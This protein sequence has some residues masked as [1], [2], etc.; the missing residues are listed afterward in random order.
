MMLLQGQAQVQI[1]GQILDK[2]KTAI[3]FSNVIILSA[4]DSMFVTG[5]TCDDIGRFDLDVSVRQD[6]I[7]KVSSIG[8]KTYMK[9]HA[10]SNE[11]KLD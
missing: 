7:L 3:P 6:F 4:K 11:G 8:Y 2:T 9:N 1:V 10:R 5:T